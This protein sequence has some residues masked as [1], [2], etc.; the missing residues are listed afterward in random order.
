VGKGKFGHALEFKKGNIVTIPLGKRAMR[1]KASVIM[2]LQFTDLGGQ[3]NY[4][5]VWDRNSNR[6]M[7]YKK[8]GGNMLRCWSNKWN[9]ISGVSAKK[10]EWYHIANVYDGKKASIDINGKEKVVQDMP[11]FE[12]FDPPQT[13]WLATDKGTGFLSSCVIDEFIFFSRAVTAKEVGEIFKK[14]IDGD[15]SVDGTGKYWEVADRLG[16]FKKAMSHRELP[17]EPL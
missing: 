3:Q 16:R 2:W 14:G 13:A 10:N 7:P 5:S 4:F 1:N 8:E 17:L 9:V 6:L 11:K 15:L 12:L